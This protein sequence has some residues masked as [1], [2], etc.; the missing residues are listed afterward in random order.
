MLQLTVEPDTNCVSFYSDGSCVPQNAKRE[1]SSR[2]NIPREVKICSEKPVYLQR[3]GWAMLSHCYNWSTCTIVGCD[4]TKPAAVCS[5]LW[6]SVEE[7]SPVQTINTSSVAR[8]VPHNSC[9]LQRN[10][11][12]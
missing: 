6:S 12:W 5:V 7:R 3:C 4:N 1:T 9:Y 10:M 2:K 11:Q 8:S